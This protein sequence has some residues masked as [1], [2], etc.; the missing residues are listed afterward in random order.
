MKW[1]REEC[2]WNFKTKHEMRLYSEGI[3]AFMT[4]DDIAQQ[5]GNNGAGRVRLWEVRGERVA[6]GTGKGYGLDGK[7]LEKDE[8]W[9]KDDPKALRE[10]LKAKGVKEFADIKEEPKPFD[11]WSATYEEMTEA[12]RQAREDDDAR[13]WAVMPEN[14]RNRG[15][16]DC[17]RATQICEQWIVAV[18]IKD[19]QSQIEKGNGNA[20]MFA[21]RACLDAGLVA[22]EWLSKAFA[23]KVSMIEKAE[24]ASWDDA[25]GRPFAKRKQLIEIQESLEIGWDIYEDVIAANM[26]GTPIDNELF[27]SVGKRFGI[28]KTRTATLYARVK[29]W[30]KNHDERTKWLT[31]PNTA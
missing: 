15:V 4:D 24:V 7:L 27:E 12:K 31:E 5:I 10:L 30:I 25:L 16:S 26:D 13:G 18:N 28:K 6:S 23:K 21:V 22:P 19:V 8:L 29:R 11:P 3:A 20:L 17:P 9:E 2:P 14:N 1:T